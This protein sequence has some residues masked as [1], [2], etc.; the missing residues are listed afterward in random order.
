MGTPEFF[1]GVRGGGRSARW[2][3]RWLHSGRDEGERR[4]AGQL[5]ASSTDREEATSQASCRR[6]SKRDGWGRRGRVA[7]SRV[8]HGSRAPPEDRGAGRRRVRCRLAASRRE[9]SPPA[10]PVTGPAAGRCSHAERVQ[11]PADRA[12]TPLSFQSGV[13][14][15]G[16]KSPYSLG[17]G[18]KRGVST[19]TPLW[20]DPPPPELKVFI[21]RRQGL[22]VSTPTPW[23]GVVCWWFPYSYISLSRKTI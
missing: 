16:L 13:P 10:L 4:G 14:E 23:F 1:A 6:D 19:S 15:I 2:T 3:L 12:N 20:S 21:R 7:A 18:G 5:S 9:S 11:E 17:S 22:R 8:D